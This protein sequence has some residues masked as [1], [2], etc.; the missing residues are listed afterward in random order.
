LLLLLL[1][2]T[3]SRTSTPAS[4]PASSSA[5]AERVAKHIRERVAAAEPTA[6]E[7]TATTARK[8]EPNVPSTSRE[9]TEST[10]STSREPTAAR[11]SPALFALSQSLLAVLVVHPSLLGIRERLVR[12]RELGERLGIT[13][14]IGVVFQRLD[15]VILLERALVGASIDAENLVEILGAGARDEG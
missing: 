5:S 9:S 1:L 4:S 11:M 12:P 13:T 2:L 3:P 10:E 8:L 7:P 14:L 6:T 15:A